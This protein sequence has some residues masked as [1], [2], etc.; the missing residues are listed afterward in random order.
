MRVNRHTIRTCLTFATIAFA[1]AVASCGSAEPLPTRLSA[2]YVLYMVDGR[3][4]PTTV[5]QR[6]G[7]QY[8][9]LADSLFFEP[10]GEV[11]RTSVIRWISTSPRASDTT[12]TQTGRFPYSI[13]GR[14]MTLGYTGGCAPNANCVGFDNGTISAG[15]VILQDRLYWPEAPALLFTRR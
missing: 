6:G 11:R 2:L 13:E 4:L 10:G 3:T 5:V 8:T 15:S 7:Q 1:T 14:A 12:Y 9:L